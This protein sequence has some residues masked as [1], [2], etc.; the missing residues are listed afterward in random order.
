MSSSAEEKFV[1]AFDT[2]AD[3]L[4]R[5][6]YFRVG[7]RERATDLAQEAFIK[8][9]DYVREGG[10]IRS[11][12]SFLYRVLNNLIIDLYRKAKE[13]SLDALLEQDTPTHSHLIAEGSRSETEER[14]DETLLIE[15]VRAHIP[16]LPESY[17]IP[18]TLRYVDGFSP[19][20]I[21]SLLG[22]SEN[23]ASVRIHRGVAQLRTWCGP[24]DTL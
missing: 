15:K 22:I 13:E 23:V 14:F 1:E 16:R 21:A 4:F 7:N 8:T 12:K 5:H 2:Y 18:L 11:W 10:E 6:A 9:W 20:E 17:R 19:K 24:R 3:A